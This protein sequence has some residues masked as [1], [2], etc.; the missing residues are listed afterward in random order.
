[1]SLI[2]EFGLES[3]TAEQQLELAHE[4]RDSVHREARPLAEAQLLDLTRRLAE[5]EGK[6][7][8]AAGWGE[9]EARLIAGLS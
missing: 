5:A 7:D 4:L 8:S 6:P 1:M 9:V 2:R 3:L